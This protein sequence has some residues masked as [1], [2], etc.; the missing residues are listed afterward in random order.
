M[1]VCAAFIFAAQMINFPIPVERQVICSAVRW[2]V[3][4]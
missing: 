4:C 1:G 3:Y 2:Q